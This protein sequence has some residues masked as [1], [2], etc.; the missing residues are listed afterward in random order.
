MAV[1]YDADTDEPIPNV[2]RVDL[3]TDD[4]NNGICEARLVVDVSEIEGEVIAPTRIPSTLSDAEFDELA[5]RIEHRM[6]ERTR[7]L[8][9][10][11]QRRDEA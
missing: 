3:V 9:G 5:K 8:A 10:Y 1:A 6:I 4:V 11:R 7:R 2:K